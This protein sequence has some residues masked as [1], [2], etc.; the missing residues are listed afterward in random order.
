MSNV[1]LEKVKALAERVVDGAT[2]CHDAQIYLDNMEE[3][4]HKLATE[5]Q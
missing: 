2:G 4:L 3:R 5:L 1:S